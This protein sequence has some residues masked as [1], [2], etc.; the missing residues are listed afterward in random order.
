MNMDVPAPARELTAALAAGI[1]SVLR[2]NVVGVEAD[3]SIAVR[4]APA[5]SVFL[6]DCLMLL[7]GSL[8]A[9][10]DEVLLVR[11][12]NQPLRGVVLGRVGRQRMPETVTLQAAESLSLRC[13]E[14]LLELR[15]D[16][17]V[18]L[19]GDDVVLRAK[20]T[21]RIRAGNVAIN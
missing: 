21:Q 17:K 11:P 2:G 16:G 9:V 3:G 8:L 15:A 4:L 12:L 6:C 7:T 5:D 13:G 14:A 19:K 10:G 1:G 20:G 18:L